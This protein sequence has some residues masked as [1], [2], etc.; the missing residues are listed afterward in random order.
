MI[1]DTSYFLNKQV[2]IPNAVAQPTVITTVPTNV[3]QLQQF[4]DE[5]EYLLLFNALGN[6]QYT[7]LLDQFEVGGA[8]KPDALPKWKDFV[9][10]K[11]QWKGLRYSLGN[12]KVSLI[13]Y[14]VYFYYLSEDWTSYTTTGIQM[15]NAENSTTVMPNDKQAKA[16][17]KFVLMYGGWIGNNLNYHFSQNWNGIYMQWGR[18]GLYNDNEYSLYRFMS[19][20]Q[21]LYSLAFFTGYSPINAM[22]L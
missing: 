2:Y 5:K 11:G 20:N 16:W 13:A 22:G 6:E 1:I 3:S 18:N 7:E 14:Y 21:D 10:G 12:A 15:P 8:W 17:N 9:D 4:I 19:E